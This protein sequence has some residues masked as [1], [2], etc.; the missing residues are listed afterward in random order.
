MREP[1]RPE[2]EQAAARP[3]LARAPAP[4]VPVR[5]REQL[6]QEP[7]QPVPARGLAP[8]VPGRE[9]QALEPGP[10]ARRVPAW[11]PPR[12]G[13]ARAGPPQSAAC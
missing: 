5:A 2:P 13:R 6:E 12:C 11:A 9:L 7:V 3:V 4:L 10:R 8:P 1:E